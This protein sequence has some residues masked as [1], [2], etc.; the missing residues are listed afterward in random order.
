MK[1]Y[2]DFFN[3]ENNATHA[4]YIGEYDSEQLTSVPGLIEQEFGVCCDIGGT[5]DTEEWSIEDSDDAD[6]DDIISFV[7]QNLD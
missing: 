4:E 3:E 7:R 6:W 2:L 5:E 1:L